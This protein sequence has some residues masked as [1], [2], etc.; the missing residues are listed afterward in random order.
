MREKKQQMEKKRL[1]TA[2]ILYAA[3]PTAIAGLCLGAFYGAARYGLQNVPD[4]RATFKHHGIDV[5]AFDDND[6]VC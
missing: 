6:V 3:I 2:D 5:R 1:E 4:Y